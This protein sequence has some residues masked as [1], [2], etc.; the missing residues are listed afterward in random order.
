MN[1]MTSY[2]TTILV[3]FLFLFNFI[4]SQT[5]KSEKEYYVSFDSFNTY[6]NVVV[7]IGLEHEDAYLEFKKGNHKF[8][9]AENFL[10]G[11]IFFDGQPY[12]DFNI[13]YDLLNDFLLLEYTNQK[14]NYLRLNEELVDEFLL[15]GDKFIRLSENQQLNGFYKNGFFKEAYKGN[16]FTLYIKYIKNKTARFRNKNVY[17]VFDG[18]EIYI[19]YYNKF[20]YRINKV[21]DIIEVFPS[22]KKQIQDFY[23]NY[24]NLFK[25]NREEF[26]DRLF[27]NLEIN[28]V[29]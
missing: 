24:K 28:D 29:N 20:Y 14:F 18:H 22:K 10:L 11:N 25:K 27:K 6:Y 1:L 26:L 13:K 8:Y 19:I 2:S 7:F 3:T 17:Y 21:K 15:D 16:N 12:Y 5:D 9:H 23:K 4:F